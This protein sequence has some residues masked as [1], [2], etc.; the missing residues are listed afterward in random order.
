MLFYDQ[1]QALNSETHAQWRIAPQASWA[2]AAKAHAVPLLAQE[3]AAAQADYTI[4][5]AKDEA[6]TYMPVALLGLK[7]EQ[8]LFVNDHGQWQA[9]VYIPAYVRRFPFAPAGEGEKMVV[10]VETS[11]GVVG[12]FAEGEPLFDNGQPT[13]TLQRAL[14]L[15]EAFHR[16]AQGTQAFC[17]WLHEKTLLTPVTAEVRA[18]EQAAHRLDGMWVIDEGRLNALPESDVLS[19]FKSG[20]LAWVYAHLMS[21]KNLSRYSVK[22]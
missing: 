22:A 4:A 10:V 8:N 3:F 20:Q 2:F 13:E 16:E 5:F 12:P 17:R 9:G 7:A 21:L 19:L 18:G 15:V 1:V 11:S 14:G 6:G